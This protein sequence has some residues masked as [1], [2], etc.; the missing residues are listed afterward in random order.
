MKK[1]GD[2][3][4]LTR[5]RFMHT[6]VPNPQD[7]GVEEDPKRN[8]DHA[9]ELEALKGTIDDNDEAIRQ[10]ELQLQKMQESI[11]KVSSDASIPLQSIDRSIHCSF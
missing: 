8:M 2:D 10:L 4:L 7:N 9:E 6:N 5:S 11:T 3:L 1:K